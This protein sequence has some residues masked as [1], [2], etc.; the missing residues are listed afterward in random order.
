MIQRGV[1]VSA[2]AGATAVSP[3][4]IAMLACTRLVI[5]DPT[6]GMQ[7]EF[8]RQHSERV[9][10]AH[11]M[12]RKIAL[13]LLSVALYAL[14]LPPWSV[15][16]L[17]WIALVPFFLVL[18]DLGP[19]AG[20]WAGLLWGTAE[21]WAFGYW[22]PGALAFYYQQPLWFSLVFSFVLSIPA[23]GSFIAGFAACACARPF[24]RA[25]ATGAILWAALWV[26]WELARGHLLTGNPWLLLGYALLP[27]PILTQAADL[28]SVYV[29]SFVVV[30]VNVALAELIAVWPVLRVALIGAPPPQE[31]VETT[32]RTAAS[33]VALAIALV[34]A[35][36]AYGNFRLAT[37]L[38]DAPRIPLRIVQGNNDL[39][40]QWRE[41][42][43]GR[44][45]SDY[46]RM[47]T[48]G[49]APPTSA[50]P[51]IVWPESAVTFFLAHEPSYRSAIT[52][53]LRPLDADLIVGAPHYEREGE[54]DV[55]QRYFNSAFYLAA[56]GTLG[57][58][59]DKRHLLPFAEYFPLR[60]IELLRRH[61]ERV[62]FFSEG[63]GPALLHTRIGPV[64]P[65]ICFEGI[66]PHLVRGPMADGAVLL[67]N[68]SNDAWLGRRG[69]PEQHLAMV[70]LRAVENRTWVVRATTTGVS[71]I[72]DPFGRVIARTAT[73]TPA[74]LDGE[75]VPLHVATFYKRF[76]DVFA[77]GCLLGLAF[78]ATVDGLRVRT[79]RRAADRTVR[80][81]EAQ[82]F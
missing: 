3:V 71:A 81:R 17:A 68:L 30:V 80:G 47:S 29:L 53:M 58:R 1:R 55:D 70:T 33:T 8:S 44:G 50:R 38:P 64:A 40:T 14:A 36:C 42:Y 34:A 13:I 10:H 11:V 12:S 2:L 72:I 45:L 66:F 5:V 74:V 46:L 62:R 23:V 32:A 39:G 35:L 73:F 27:R 61:F 16:P 43:Y 28:G 52:R 67:V 75:I 24:R 18:R 48:D 21:N 82:I 19:A 20:A 56:D 22:V 78:V 31:A 7:P 65:V 54:G 51:M 57:E 41:E 6:P 59:Y 15:W 63:E 76:G 4:A 49:W 37:P 69:G 60:T 77:Y 79:A 26:V 9:R 25:G